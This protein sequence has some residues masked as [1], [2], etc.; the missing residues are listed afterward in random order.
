MINIKNMGQGYLPGLEPWRNMYS[1]RKLKLLENSWAGVFRK[2]I[3]PLLPAEQIFHLYSSNRGRPTKE[4]YSI[5]GATVLQQFF[6]LTDSET[7]KELAFNE[8]WHFALE[9]FDEDNQVIS[10]KTLWTMRN[11]V[12]KLGL[13]KQIFTV[14]TDHLIKY[15]NVNVSKQRIDS[16]HV[17]SNMARLG[18]IRILGRTIIKFLKNLKRQHIEIFNAEISSEMQAK[19]LK[20]SDDSYFGQL[21]P[22]ESE[23][24]L[25]TL[26][27]DMYLLISIFSSEAVVSNMTSFKLLLRVFS[28]QCYVENEQVV[29]KSSK[30]VSS[31]SVQNP[32]DPDSGYDGHKG[33]G[34]QTQIMETYSSKENKKDDGKN[35]KGNEETNENK[36][37]LNLITYVET[38][39]A[40][41]HDSQALKPA[42]EDM[43]ER[44]LKSEKVAGDTSYGSDKNKEIAKNFGVEL[45]SPTP[46]KASK[47]G[48][49][50]FNIDSDS[51]EILSCQSNKKPDVIKHNKK[52]SI[53]L[54]WY[55][56]TCANC[57]FA[58]SC[59][60]KKCRKG[61]KITYRKESIKFF[62]R[63]QYEESIE[64]KEEYRYRS[65][66]EATNSRFIHMTGA[67]RLRYRGLEKMR[68]GQ[69][70]RAL[71]INVFRTAKYLRKID[72]FFN[73]LFFQ[74]NI[75]IFSFEINSKLK[76]AA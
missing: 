58:D 13:S 55:R 16:V 67:R 20:K 19:Y 47:K 10:E 6:D 37:N 50:K 29:L 1:P 28:E 64:F 31:D 57:S 42:L 75:S 63:R 23:R 59:P 11:Y 17:H 68:F 62:I 72:K 27:H 40:S 18:R 66:I 53:T 74:T 70:L 41:K 46:G 60:T 69:K 54:L 39:S 3:L 65:G 76:I 12:V 5:I 2:H 9:C 25:S 4:L 52:G 71:A 15:F 8:Q 73:I 30:E 35:D 49:D 24:N 43:Q 38:E 21:K 48:F 44:G 7:I 56:S 32:S 51:F 61:R 33:Q 14:A 36:P 22:S 45:I 26:A 34:F